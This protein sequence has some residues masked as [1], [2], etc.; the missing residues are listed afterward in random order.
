MK[1]KWDVW[2]FPYC[3]M[4]RAIEDARKFMKYLTG[5]F[6]I[7]I[8]HDLDGAIVWTAAQT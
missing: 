2:P 1:D 8:I 7:R 5:A 6:Q 4:D 3:D